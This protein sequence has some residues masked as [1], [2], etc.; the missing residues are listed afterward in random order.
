[1]TLQKLELFNTSFVYHSTIASRKRTFERRWVRIWCKHTRNRENRQVS[2][3]QHEAKIVRVRVHVAWTINLKIEC[4]KSCQNKCRNK[5]NREN[6]KHDKLRNSALLQLNCQLGQE[7]PRIWISYGF[8]QT[9][10]G[11]G[12]GRTK[13]EHQTGWWTDWFVHL[14]LRT[15]MQKSDCHNSG[16]RWLKDMCCAFGIAL[17]SL[18]LILWK[19]VLGLET[20]HTLDCWGLK[21]P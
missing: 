10:F 16:E 9:S 19:T 17:Y 13:L 6:P 15:L 4:W 20:V 14:N 7:S 21:V 18:W 5:T 11:H 1:M 8:Y 12:R 3:I 2:K